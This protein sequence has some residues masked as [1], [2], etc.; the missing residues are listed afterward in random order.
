MATAD[1]HHWRVLAKARTQQRAKY[2]ASQRCT[3]KHTTITALLLILTLTSSC[4]DNK[5][6]DSA[7]AKNVHLHSS[8]LLPAGLCS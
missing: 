3:H 4:M 5:C 8:I 1:T 6:D 7:R 2:T